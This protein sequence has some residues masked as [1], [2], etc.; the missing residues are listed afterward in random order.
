MLQFVG[1]SETRTVRGYVD[2][3][4]KAKVDRRINAVLRSYMN[5]TRKNKKR[6]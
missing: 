2:A 5:A 1:P 3:L 4:R 6:A